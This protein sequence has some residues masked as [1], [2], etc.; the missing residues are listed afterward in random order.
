MKITSWSKSTYTKIGLA[1]LLLAG[2]L[3]VGSLAIYTIIKADRYHT[4]QLG[5]AQEVCKLAGY[6]YRRGIVN[7]IMDLVYQ[8]ASGH[9]EIEA[10]SCVHGVEATTLYPIGTR[11]V[12]YHF[13]RRPTTY[14]S[15]PQLEAVIRQNGTNRTPI[16]LAIIGALVFFCIGIV[17]VSWDMKR[18]GQLED[19]A[20]MEEEAYRMTGEADI[21][22]DE[23]L[24]HD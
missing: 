23:E 2:L 20:P 3:G 8:C 21:A 12:L 17:L 7:C 9:H 1:T 16:F 14:Y 10:P 4:V 6:T 11:T 15:R 19:Y 13:V 5:Y 18:R 22:D 24:P